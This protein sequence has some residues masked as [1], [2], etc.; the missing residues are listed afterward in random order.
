M[1]TDYFVFYL[2]LRTKLWARR[3]LRLYFFYFLCVSF[4]VYL[5]KLY[6]FTRWILRNRLFSWLLL[7]LD[8]IWNGTFFFR[9]FVF[10]NIL[11]NYH[12]LMQLVSFWINALWR[13]NHRSF[14]RLLTFMSVWIAFDSL[15]MNNSRRIFNCVFG[16]CT[17]GML[18]AWILANLNL[19]T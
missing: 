5:L 8:V 14:F 4:N 15:T 11:H 7:K 16:P 12:G 9:V 13:L 19:P 17:S 18:V 2:A 6:Y 10:M 3:S 1:S